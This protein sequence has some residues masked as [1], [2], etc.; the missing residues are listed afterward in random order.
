MQG[1]LSPDHVVV[2]ARVE[3]VSVPDIERSAIPRGSVFECEI[4]HTCQTI[5]ELFCRT[6]AGSVVHLLTRTR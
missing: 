4:S 6:W 5:S 1:D 3:Q 2:F